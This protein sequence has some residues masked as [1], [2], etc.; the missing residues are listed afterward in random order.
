MS[1]GSLRCNNV[2]IS[3]NIYDFLLQQ[4]GKSF[5]ILKGLGY[6]R[7]NYAQGFKQKLNPFIIFHA[8]FKTN[9][10]M[11]IKFEISSPRRGLLYYKLLTTSQ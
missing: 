4:Q 7:N 5:R 10:L 2:I 6:I 1:H 9:L 11:A 8:Y 3:A